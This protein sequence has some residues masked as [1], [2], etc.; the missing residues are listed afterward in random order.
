MKWNEEVNLGASINCLYIGGVKRA[1]TTT[2]ALPSY[3]NRPFASSCSILRSFMLVHC[4]GSSSDSRRADSMAQLGCW[5]AA[6]PVI[7]STN[8]TG[9][10]MTIH[11]EA[12]TTTRPQVPCA[13]ARAT[14]NCPLSSVQA[15]VGRSLRRTRNTAT[16][17][18]IPYCREGHS[19]IFITSTCCTAQFSAGP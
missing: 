8:Q 2:S 4:L 13:P 19:L 1:M 17:P 3:S 7:R 5:S 10:S 6:V 14:K 16:P 11:A 18:W 9:S 12:A 15:R